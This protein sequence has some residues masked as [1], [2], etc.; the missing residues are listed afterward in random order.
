MKRKIIQIATAGHENVS[1]TQCNLTLFALCDDGTLWETNDQ[2]TTWREVS[3]VPQSEATSFLTTDGM[4]VPTLSQISSACGSFRH[5]YGLLDEQEQSEIRF[6]A[7]EWLRA[8]QK[9][10]IFK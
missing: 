7:V 4:T 1:A 6:E 8:W 2:K 9:E 5:D 3:P 10:G